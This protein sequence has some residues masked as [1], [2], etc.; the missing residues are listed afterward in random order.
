M[1]FKKLALICNLGKFN[2]NIDNLPSNLES[3]Y[4][5]VSYF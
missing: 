2:N 3:I 4:V 1:K 5:L